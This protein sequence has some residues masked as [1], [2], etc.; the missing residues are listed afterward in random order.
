[1]P[2]APSIS[3]GLRS[4]SNGIPSDRKVIDMRDRIFDYD[5]GATPTLTI[6]TRRGRSLLARAPVYNHLEDQPMPWWDVIATAPGTT[7]ATT[8]TVTNGA[9]FR[10]GDVIQVPSSTTVVG[11]VM[12]VT[13]VAGNVLTVVRDVNNSGVTGGGISNGATV[14]II[15]D[16]S[17]EGSGTRTLKATVETTVTNYCQI[18]KTPYG[19]SRTMEGQEMYGPAERSRLRMKAGKEHELRIE[20]AFLFGKKASK[21]GTN[22]HPERYTGGLLSLISSNITN[23]GGTLTHATIEALAEIG[24]RYGSSRKLLIASRRVATQLDNIAMGNIRTVAAQDNYGVAVR[25]YVTSHGSLDI[26]TSDMFVQDYAG[27]AVLVDFEHLWKRF[28]RDDDGPRDARL[29][30]DIQLPDEDQDKEQYLSEVGFHAEAEAAF[31]V[32]KGVA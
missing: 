11:E 19:L 29:E 2:A 17:E 21:T 3:T 20:R 7:T 31:A 14:A 23:A 15:G 32:L 5:A 1:M 26:I 12:K 22:G 18:F 24:F 6:L 28:L 13:G 30:Q 25:E 16:V 9:Y 8:M 27:Y 10:A 4:G